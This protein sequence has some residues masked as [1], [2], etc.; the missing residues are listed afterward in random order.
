MNNG[1]TPYRRFLIVVFWLLVI[2]LAVHFLHDLEAG[3]ADLLG[4]ASRV[5]SLAIHS[6]LL[7]GM[8]PAVVLAVLVLSVVF[9]PRLYT[10]FE[11]LSVPIPPP[12][13]P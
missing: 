5:C 8:I 2:C 12:I 11:C 9:L 4:S 7:A 13:Q 6:G 1:S 3:H 10:R